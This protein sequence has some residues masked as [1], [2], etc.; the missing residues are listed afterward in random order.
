MTA[1]DN[2]RRALMDTAERLD[3]A[4][5]QVT[6]AQWEFDTAKRAVLELEKEEELPQQNDE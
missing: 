5:R 1:L 6:K 3:D 4:Q 2:A